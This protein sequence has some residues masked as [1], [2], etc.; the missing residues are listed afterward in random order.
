M[1]HYDQ[2]ILVRIPDI[3]YGMDNATMI[4]AAAIH[5]IQKQDFT[6]WQSLAADP[7]WHIGE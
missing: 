5:R 3:K 2:N 1:Q 4:A 6:P 7:N